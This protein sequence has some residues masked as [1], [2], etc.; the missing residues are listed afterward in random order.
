MKAKLGPCAAI[1]ATAHKIALL[2]YTMVLHQA[3]YDE[4]F[5]ATRDAERQ[6]R[7]ETNSS[8]KPNIS[9]TNWSP[10][11]ISPPHNEPIHRHVR[12][13]SLEGFRVRFFVCV[14]HCCRTQS[15]QL[16]NGVHLV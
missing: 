1:T 3:E 11:A 14:G 6:K 8:G 12:L 4:T 2:F 13:S 7:L 16:A 9:A 15:L 10:L 5:W